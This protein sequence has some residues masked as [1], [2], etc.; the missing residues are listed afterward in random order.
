M[1][2]YSATRWHLHEFNSK[3]A[4]FNLTYCYSWSSPTAILHMDE[5][6][7]LVL[8]LEVQE[9]KCQGNIPGLGFSAFG[10]STTT[11]AGGNPRAI[12]VVQ[13]KNKQDRA[14]RDRGIVRHPTDAWGWD[15]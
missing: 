8:K 1:L 3:D 4:R 7:P 10:G 5:L 14:P 2:D 12:T 9:A 6:V 15:A 11:D 13:E